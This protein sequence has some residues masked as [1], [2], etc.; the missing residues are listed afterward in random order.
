MNAAKSLNQ[1]RKGSSGRCV[2]FPCLARSGPHHELALISIYFA[3]YSFGSPNIK[4]W[5]WNVGS[6]KANQSNITY[7]ACRHCMLRCNETYHE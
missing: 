6:S 7:S 5:F 4:Y 2:H 3:E 1:V